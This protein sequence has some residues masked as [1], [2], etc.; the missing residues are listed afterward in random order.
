MNALPVTAAVDEYV[1][2]CVGVRRLCEVDLSQ[3]KRN[4][5]E[6][7]IRTFVER[8]GAR[9]LAEYLR[10]LNDDPEE[11]DRFLDRVTINVS[12]LW[13]NPSQ[14]TLLAREVL[15]ELG[16]EGRIRAW[17]AGSSYGAEAYTLAAVCLEAV[18]QAQVTIVGTDIDRRMVDQARVGE[19]SDADARDAPKA[20]LQRWF[21]RTPSGWL[22]GEELRA[23]TSF[24]RGDLLRL[25]ARPNSYDLI[26]CRNTAIYFT[27]DVRDT[28][29]AG[30]AEALR[31]GGYLLVGSTERVSEPA[32]VGLS[33]VL[34]FTYRKS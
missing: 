4:Q 9:G 34:P 32:A 6:R 13:R 24:E 8:R 12:Q 16:K 17:S 3:Y 18:P 7:R 30:L 31:A 33:P 25:R 29:H 22:A 20:A 21:E 26:L 2:F 14:W 28:L 27:E 15:P 5:M 10:Q 1:T 23:V 11:L 19:F